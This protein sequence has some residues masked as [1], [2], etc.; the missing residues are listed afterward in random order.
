MCQRGYITLGH[1]TS[2]THY[3]CVDK[4]TSDIRIVYN[5]TSCGLNECLHAHHYGVLL[6]MHTLQ[7]LREGYYQCNLDVGKQFLNFKLH[8]NLRQL[9]RVDVRKVRSRDPAA[10]PRE[11]SLHPGRG[12]NGTG[13]GCG[14]PCT[15]ACSG[16]RA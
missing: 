15:A 14:T 6:V 8:D 2:G 4:G 16:R 9:S 3:F 10:R 1:V 5:G 11:A 13:W 7:A 12:R